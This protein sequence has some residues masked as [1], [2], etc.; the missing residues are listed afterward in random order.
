MTAEELARARKSYLQESRMMPCRRSRFKK[1]AKK[2]KF[3]TIRTPKWLKKERG[4]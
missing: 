3:E 2:R 1:K 4:E